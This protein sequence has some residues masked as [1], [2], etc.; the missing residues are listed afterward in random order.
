MTLV[1]LEYVVAVANY[2]HIGLAAEHCHVTQPTLSMQLQK[3]EESLG[4]VIFDRSRQ[5]VMPTPIGE[6]IVEQARVILAESKKLQ[7][8]VQEGKRELVDELKIGIIPTIASYLVPGFISNFLESNPGISLSVVEDM[9]DNL[10]RSLREDK[11]DAAIL[12]TPLRQQGLFQQVLF[13]E[14]FCVFA[15]DAHPLLKLKNIKP[16]DLSDVDLWMLSEGHCLRNQAFRLCS[17]SNENQL[18]KRFRYQPGNLHSLLGL[19]RMEKGYTIIPTLAVDEFDE[20]DKKNIRRFQKP[21]P[22]REIS[23]VTHRNYL[24][25]ASLDALAENIISQIP[26][27]MKT[28]KDKQILDI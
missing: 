11:L 26:E 14:P 8:L 1:Q 21:Y 27:G 12:A 2:H 15:S 18:Q 6:R 5:P 13:Y 28:Y 7:S 3:L 25:K 19:V 17:L 22:S 24:K 9:T 20:Q 23:L 10:V 16:G 4:V